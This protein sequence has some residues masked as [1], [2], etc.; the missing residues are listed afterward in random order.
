MDVKQPMDMQQPTDVQQPMDMFQPMDMWQFMIYRW[1]TFWFQ[2][3]ARDRFCAWGR[4]AMPPKQR[5]PQVKKRSRA[6]RST[7]G[8]GVP[9]GHR[10][11]SRGRRPAGVA[12]AEKQAAEERKAAARQ[13]KAA[14][15]AVRAKAQADAKGERSRKARER[16]LAA[17]DKAEAAARA[18][19]VA[20]RKHYQASAAV[21]DGND[22]LCA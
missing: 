3:L 13:L 16:A 17:V 10:L 19:S 12:A 18:S 11:S 21:L 1:P 5:R 15:R 4:V 14:T 6:K 8:G 7:G 20:R 9:E 22:Q 2:R